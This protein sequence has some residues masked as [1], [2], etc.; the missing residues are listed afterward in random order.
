MEKFNLLLRF[1]SGIIF[2]IGCVCV[3]YFAGKENIVLEVM[4]SLISIISFIIF[5]IG[6]G[7]SNE[8]D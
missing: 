6:K 4:F 8:G 1:I 3:G 5:Y 7:K 2:I